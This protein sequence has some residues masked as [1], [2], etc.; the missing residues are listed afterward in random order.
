MIP[1]LLVLLLVLILFGAG[2]ALE[3]LWWIAAVILVLWLLGFVIRPAASGGRR[4]RWYR[5]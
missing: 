4:S 1:L 5:W 3:A 2:F